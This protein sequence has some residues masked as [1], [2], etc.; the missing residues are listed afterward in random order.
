MLLRARLDERGEV[1]EEEK[2]T[3]EIRAAH[4]SS[5]GS[6]AAVAEEVRTAQSLSSAGSEEAVAEE[7]RAAQSLMGGSWA[8]GVAALVGAL[9]AAVEERNERLEKQAALAAA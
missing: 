9:R 1:E 3:E 6:E 8:A 4:L 2:A 5:A 7:V